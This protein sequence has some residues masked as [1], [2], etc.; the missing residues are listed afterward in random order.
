MK[1]R[2]RMRK[3][4]S[5]LLCV[6][7]LT[8]YV[9]MNAFASAPAE[10]G[11]CEHHATHTADCGYAAAVA[12]ADCTYH[13]QICHVQ[14]LVDALP[15]EVTAEN[16]ETVKAKLTAIDNEKASLSDEELAQVDFAKYTA[17]ISAINELSVQSS[18][19][20]PAPVEDTTHATAKAVATA[21]VPDFE[22]SNGVLVK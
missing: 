7:M 5:I 10:D 3:C 4:F 18:A 22:I 6:L 2:E 9:P 1:T 8:Q 13:C 12:G 17:A 11:L 14:E 21:E 19:Q 16:V 20:K 15:E